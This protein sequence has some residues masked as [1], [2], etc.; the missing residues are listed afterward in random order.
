MCDVPAVP[1]R[2][3]PKIEALSQVIFALRHNPR[4]K[5]ELSILYSWGRKYYMGSGSSGVPMN[6]FHF[7]NNRDWILSD[8][9]APTDI[10]VVRNAIDDIQATIETP[11]P[12]FDLTIQY[13][14][15]RDRWRSPE[16]LAQIRY[17]PVGANAECDSGLQTS[18]DSAIGNCE[19]T[20]N[21]LLAKRIHRD[22][23]ICEQIESLP[24]LR[25]ESA[26]SELETK[27]RDDYVLAFPGNGE[28][29]ESPSG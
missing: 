26:C 12:S 15:Y 13:P 11:V 3:S 28:T 23:W 21:R 24:R 29:E 18:E 6:L 10:E 9:I 19:Y 5:I 16:D 1:N 8:S 27:L 4:C 20:Y 2:I 22:A 14:D 7:T 25:D 17:R